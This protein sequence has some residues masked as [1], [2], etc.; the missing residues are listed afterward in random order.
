MD[1]FSKELSNKVIIT[2]NTLSKESHI[3]KMGNKSKQQRQAYV[4]FS[5]L[6]CEHALWYSS[7]LHGHTLFC[8]KTLTQNAMRWLGIQLLILCLQRRSKFFSREAE[9]TTLLDV[10]PVEKERS[11]ISGALLKCRIASGGLLVEVQ[12]SGC[13]RWL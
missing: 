5:F 2:D 13:R 8:H 6:S 1:L 9:I 7:Y 11:L 10:T 4:L 3:Q 12:R